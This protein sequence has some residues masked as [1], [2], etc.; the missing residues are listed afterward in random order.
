[1]PLHE[2]AL[3]NTGILNSWFN[4][5]DSVILEVIEDNAMSDSVIFVWVFNDWF[6]EVSLEFK[7]LFW[8]IKK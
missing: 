4:N 2:D 5:V 8:L 6:L 1:M 3:W 7:Y